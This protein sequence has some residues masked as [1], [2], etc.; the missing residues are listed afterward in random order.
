MVLQQQAG[1]LL[2]GGGASQ[3]RSRTPAGPLSSA[4]GPQAPKPVPLEL[5]VTLLRV[6]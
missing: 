5:E 1:Y 6:I 4:A 2:L 3:R